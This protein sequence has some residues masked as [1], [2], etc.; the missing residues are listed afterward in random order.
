LND[1]YTYIYASASLVNDLTITP[2]FTATVV[3]T[4]VCP[5]AA[6]LEFWDEPTLQ[7]RYENTPQAVSSTHKF[8]S[9]FDLVDAKT[10]ISEPDHTRY[11]ITHSYQVRLKVTLTDS[12]YT[13]NTVE[14]LFKLTIKHKCADNKIALD[15]SLANVRAGASVQTVLDFTYTI[16]DA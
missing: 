16:G 1:A 11:G 13:A 12:L 7:Y 4:E 14:Y 3:S 6:T 9:T 2:A 15:N 5:T 8:V 10:V